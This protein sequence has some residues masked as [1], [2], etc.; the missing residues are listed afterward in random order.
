MTCFSSDWVKWGRESQLESLHKV[1]F[2]LGIFQE[3][4][5]KSFDRGFT[6][7]KLFLTN[8]HQSDE[9]TAIKYGENLK[10]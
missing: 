6:I 5:K 8:L 1:R 4:V 10:S 9:S 7:S 3:N 2:Q